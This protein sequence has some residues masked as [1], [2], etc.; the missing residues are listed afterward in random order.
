ML[1]R[2]SK[3][4]LPNCLIL[5][6]SRLRYREVRWQINT[7]HGQLVEKLRTRTSQAKRLLPKSSHH[8]DERLSPSQPLS[9]RAV[10]GSVAPWVCSTTPPFQKEETVWL[11]PGCVHSCLYSPSHSTKAALHWIPPQTI[12]FW[13]LGEDDPRVRNYKLWSR[14]YVPSRKQ[15]HEKHLAVLLKCL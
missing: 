2:N 6:G 1:K 7:M 11:V 3:I 8:Q 13:P 15:S 10:P 12:R 4:I 5:L 14:H 9:P